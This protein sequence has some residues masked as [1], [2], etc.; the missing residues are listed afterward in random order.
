MSVKSCNLNE[1]FQKIHEKERKLPDDMVRKLSDL[2]N[3][4]RIL[5]TKSDENSKKELTIVEEKL[6]ELCAKN[7][8][9]TIMNEIQNFSPFRPQSQT[10]GIFIANFTPT[11]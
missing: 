6:A 5:R 9:L 3:K 8:Y 7:N 4:R 2:F 10:N 11:S 1:F